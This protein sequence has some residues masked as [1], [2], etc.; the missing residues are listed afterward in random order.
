MDG[1]LL[2]YCV[3]C[4]IY[5]SSGSHDS[6]QGSPSV[7]GKSPETSTRTLERV[8]F[9][10]AARRHCRPPVDSVNFGQAAGRGLWVSHKAQSFQR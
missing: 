6:S 5:S 2:F 7:P 9:G 3:I 4:F 10:E 1:R 8:S